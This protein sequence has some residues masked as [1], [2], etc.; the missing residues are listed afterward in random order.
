VCSTLT[1]GLIGSSVAAA[2]VLNLLSPPTTVP[3]PP[4]Y[5]KKW[6][7]ALKSLIK[8]KQVH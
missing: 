6:S 5:Q 8:N 7:M 4:E 3:L 2:V 1:A